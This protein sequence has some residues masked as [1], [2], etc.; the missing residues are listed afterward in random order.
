MTES[1]RKYQEEYDKWKHIVISPGKYK[2]KS[3]SGNFVITYEVISVDTDAETVTLKNPNNG[4]TK[5]KTLHWARKN[6][7]PLE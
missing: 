5:S 1:Q 4:N 2:Q 3:S 7:K 6:L